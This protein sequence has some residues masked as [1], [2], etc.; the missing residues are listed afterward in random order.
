M[1]QVNRVLD[2]QPVASLREYL[3]AG[4]GAGLEA[5]AKLGAA[6][7]IEELSAAGLR[8]RGGAGFPTG[9]KWATVLENRPAG[10][11]LTVVVNAA[12][13]EPGTFKDRTLIRTNP[14]R[15]LEGALIAARTLDAQR[16][17]VALKASFQTEIGLMDSAIAAATTEGW[18]EGL[19]VTTFGGPE[20]YLLG[21]ETGLLEAIEGRPPFPR[22]SPPYRRGLD[23]SGADNAGSADKALADSAGAGTGAAPTLINNAETF[24]HVAM[25]LAN[26]ADWFRSEGTDA[27]PGTV[28]C[29]VSGNTKRHGVGEFP[30]GT[31]LSEVIETLGGL[32]S[33]GTAFVA[34]SSGV[35]NP[36]LPASRFDTPL[37]YDELESAGTAI[38]AAGF[39]V[40]DDS[41]D[42]VAVVAGISRFLAVESCGQC[43][44]CKRDGLGL[45]DLLG[46]M[47]RSLTGD[48][49][50]AVLV[51]LTDRVRTVSEEARCYLAHQ[52]EAVVGSLL[53]L[54][55]DHLKQRAAGGLAAVE[56]LDIAPI[57]DIDEGRAVLDRRQSTKQPDWTHNET[58]SAKWPAQ[59]ADISQGET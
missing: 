56:P 43:T 29:T 7:T 37:G 27:S 15:I 50:E 52:Q 19:E 30:M 46:E 16:V 8:G 5:A 1:P 36:L 24:A 57:S 38:G 3:T 35:A 22:V 34:A 2:R 11:P 55:P 58:D 6:S 59:Q 45:A 4:G 53:S 49:A 26:G 21:E 20:E 32:P 39:I 54:F 31:P 44:P 10:A 17:I 25:I 40:F 12:E 41:V 14:F 18:I 13:G 28:V 33:P 9:T 47:S 42:I 23:S 48:R 51:E